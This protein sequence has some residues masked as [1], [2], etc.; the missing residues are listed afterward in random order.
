MLGG[1]LI[2]IGSL[3]DAEYVVSALKNGAW[4]EIESIWNNS[5][6]ND[7]KVSFHLHDCCS[8]PL[9]SKCD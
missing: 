4:E 2:K 3:P 8:H 6:F 9:K 5:T 7:K 1:V